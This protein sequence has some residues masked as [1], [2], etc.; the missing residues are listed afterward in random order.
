MFRIVVMLALLLPAAALAQTP[1]A[2]PTPG[3]PTAAMREP[4]SR[5]QIQ[6]MI[7]DRG[8]F[9]I[10]GLEQG[11]NGSWHCTALAGPGQRVALTLD[12]NGAIIENDVPATTQ[13]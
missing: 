10:D 9:E 6:Q 12:Q 7:A 1:V 8:Y 13:R 4:L 3:K 11:P 2:A 5:A